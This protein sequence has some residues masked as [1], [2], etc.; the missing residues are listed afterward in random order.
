MTRVSL[1]SSSAQKVFGFV[2]FSRPIM[3]INSHAIF[4]N[5]LSDTGRFLPHPKI[6]LDRKCVFNKIPLMYMRC[7][8]IVIIVYLYS[9][10]HTH[11]F[12]YSYTFIGYAHRR[13][14]ISL[15]LI[16]V[17]FWCNA[18][19]TVRA[20]IHTFAIR[21][22]RT[23]GRLST[24]PPHLPFHS[25]SG[26]AT[27]NTAAIK[28]PPLDPVISLCRVITLNIYR[29]D[30]TRTE[31]KVPNLDHFLDPYT[32]LS[33]CR[34]LSFFVMRGVPDIKLQHINKRKQFSVKFG[35]YNHF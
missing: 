24:S 28:L 25:N 20:R 14:Q 16:V 17:C 10:T 32:S 4:V 19:V 33:T 27:M 1:F 3:K 11:T 23:P 21:H 12:D 5:V 31:G 30:F 13:I 7:R 26:Y 35:T 34:K 22:I 2:H 15:N 8:K 29:N 18:C 9:N 6:V